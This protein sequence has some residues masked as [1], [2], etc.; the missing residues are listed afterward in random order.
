MQRPHKSHKILSPEQYVEKHAGHLGN[1]VWTLNVAYGKEK[2]T[3]LIAWVSLNACL[4]GHHSPRRVIPLYL[5]L[6]H[7]PL[8]CSA[9]CNPL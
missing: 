8:P 3:L 4:E 6:L 9:V 1:K 5:T 2:K 7:T